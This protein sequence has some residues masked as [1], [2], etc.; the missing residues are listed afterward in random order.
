MEKKLLLL[1][2]LLSHDVHGYELSEMLKDNPSIAIEM[3]KPNT[4]RLLNALEKDGLIT[5]T[6]EQVGNRPTRRVYSI[7]AAGKEE[8]RRLLT[9]S[10]A[11]YEEPQFPAMVGFDFISLLP[12]RE[13]IELLNQR[14]EII[15]GKVQTFEDLPAEIL[16]AHPTS[17]YLKNF[18]E[19]EVSWLK[20]FISQLETQ[21][22]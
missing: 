4:Y 3:K 11:A 17:A 10:I 1:G 15:E 9:A 8:F 14:L 7:T 13:T 12:T 22:D 16:D 6:E 18:Y 21:I 19:K 5:H 2:V 20:E